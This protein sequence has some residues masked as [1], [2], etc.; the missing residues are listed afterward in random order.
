ML[1]DL[2]QVDDPLESRAAG[3]L[4][5]HVFTRDRANR[6]HF[7]EALFHAIAAA[8]FH[9]RAHPDAHAAGDFAAPD[10]IAELFC[11]EHVCLLLLTSAQGDAMKSLK[12][13]LAAGVLVLV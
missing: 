8:D 7:H 10:A 6:L 12:L 9:A 2:Q 5:R 4:R 13:I 1:R 3:E 11:E